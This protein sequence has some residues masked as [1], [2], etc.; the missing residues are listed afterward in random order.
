[1][2]EFNTV[3]E[4]VDAV[5]K[6]IKK[7]S[8][9]ASFVGVVKLSLEKGTNSGRIGINYQ[10]FRIRFGIQVLG[11][12]KESASPSAVYGEFFGKQR[13]FITEI[14]RTSCKERPNSQRRNDDCRDNQKFRIL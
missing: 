14:K 12:F 6:E 11:S 1:M 4:F 2:K 8:Q 5:V 9:S 3:N 13:A 7:M 10:F